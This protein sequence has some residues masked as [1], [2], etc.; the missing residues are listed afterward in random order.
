MAVQKSRR[1]PSTRGK[2][3]SHDSLKARAL[4]VNTM[5][6]EVHRRHHI[7][8]AGYHKNR[9]VLPPKKRRAE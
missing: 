7:S 9:Q 4:S 8:P 5:T 1:S 3:R 6:G 2:R